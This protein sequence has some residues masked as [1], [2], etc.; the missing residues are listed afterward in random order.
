MRLTDSVFRT[1]SQ[2]SGPMPQAYAILAHVGF[3]YAIHFKLP[4]RVRT[5][6]IRVTESSVRHLG[7]VCL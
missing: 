7:I 1:V 4:W 6:E 2:H 5:L 3:A